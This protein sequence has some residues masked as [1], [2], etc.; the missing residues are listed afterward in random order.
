MPDDC[1][2]RAVQS[3]ADFWVPR[4]IPYYDDLVQKSVPKPDERVLVTSVGPGAELRAVALAMEQKGALF[5][6]DP[7]PAMITAARRG[8]TDAE[9][10]MPVSFEVTDAFDTLGRQWDLI[11]SAF[12]LWQIPERRATLQKW[13][14]AVQPRGRIGILVWGPPDPDGPFEMVSAA[15]QQVEPAIGELVKAWELA[16]RQPMRDM[17]ADAGLK[18]IR[19][20]TVRHDMEFASAEGFFAAMRSGCSFLRVCDKLGAERTERVAEAFFAQLDPPSSRTPLAFAPS[21]AIAI[22]EPA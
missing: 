4:L 8:L 15:L 6:T 14:R 13:G 3:Y 11:L 18:L 19:H 20:A 2:D 22:A 5:A 21:A 9:V 1:W 16:A 10:G 12:S 7:S 17:L